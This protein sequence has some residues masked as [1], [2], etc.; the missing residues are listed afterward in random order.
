MSNLEQPVYEAR[1]RLIVGQALSAANP[2]YSQLLVAQ[3]LTATYAVVAET[4]TILGAVGSKL[5]PP[6]SP[7]ALA[8]RVQVDAPRDSTFLYIT[9]QDTVPARAAAIANTLADQLIAASPSIQGREA[10]FQQSIDQDLAATQALIDRT[11]ARADALI[12]VA[13]PTAQ[14]ETELL[15]LEGRLASLRSTYTTLLSFSSGSATNL[16]TVLDPAATPT[17]PISPRV[18]FNTLLAAA[19]GMLVVV[20][21]AFVAEQL[22]D[23]IKDPDAVQDVAGLS[24]LGTIARMTSRRGRKDFYQLAG[25]LFPRSSFAEAYRTLRTNIEFASLDTPVRT[26]LVTSSAQGEGKTVTAA[27][28]PSS[29]LSQGER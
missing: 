27:N 23:R 11:Q 8:S 3:N 16:L 9:A 26:L 14:E 18:L 21:V 7:G 12:E 4:S 25:L 10:V 28:L 15:A 19:L 13:D 6:L 20:A 2:D 22:D 29:L 24:T 1:T 5:S 17:A